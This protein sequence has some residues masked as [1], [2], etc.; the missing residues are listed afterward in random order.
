MRQRVDE[1]KLAKA[2]YLSRTVS[3]TQACK[4]AGI[5]RTTFY[6]YGFKAPRYGWA[7]QPVVVEQEK[8]SLWD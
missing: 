8:D 1:A 2:M 6:R 4:E 3:V 7:E 5:G